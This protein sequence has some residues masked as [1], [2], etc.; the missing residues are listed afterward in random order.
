MEIDKNIEDLRII[1][2]SGINRAF[3]IFILFFGIIIWISTV[4]TETAIGEMTNL[5]AGTILVGIGLGMIIKARM[6]IKKL[7]SANQT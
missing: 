2:D 4:F 7:N 3:G 5:V 1:K 6:N